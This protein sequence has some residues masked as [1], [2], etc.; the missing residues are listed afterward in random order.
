MLGTMARVDTAEIIGEM[1]AAALISAAERLAELIAHENTD[2]RT[3][4]RLALAELCYLGQSL[5]L[6]QRRAGL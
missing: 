4:A 3:A 5:N 2:V 6:E 1:R